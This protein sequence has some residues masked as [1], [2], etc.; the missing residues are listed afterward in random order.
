MKKTTLIITTILV[1]AALVW[2]G[3]EYKKVRWWMLQDVEF[4]KEWNDDIEG[5]LEKPVFGQRVLD[6]DGKKIEIAGY[7]IP[8]DISSG[9]Y[10]LSAYPFSQCYFCGGAGPESVVELNISGKS[11]KFKTDDYVTFRGNF[12]L[13]S[14]D[15]LHLN[16]IL[17]EAAVHKTDE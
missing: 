9:D 2:A 5:Y 1:T 17:D 14:T 15:M 13:N 3:I 4:K 12:R 11:A 16:Y 7:V 10:V 8:V 6:L